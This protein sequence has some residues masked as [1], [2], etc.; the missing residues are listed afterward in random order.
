LQSEYLKQLRYTVESHCL[1]FLLIIYAKTSK[2]GKIFRLKRIA[3]AQKY[4]RS[5]PPG[6][7]AGPASAPLPGAG[8]ASQE[9][10]AEALQLLQAKQK[11]QTSP[12][13]ID[14][15]NIFRQNEWIKKYLGQNG[16]IKQMFSPAETKAMGFYGMLI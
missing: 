10:P 12:K 14:N 2:N 6:R 4:G 3:A 9:P 7:G 5:A 16:S 8:N 15:N 13:R 1:R 11:S